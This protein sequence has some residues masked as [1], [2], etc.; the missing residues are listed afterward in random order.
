[1]SEMSDFF[2][3]QS[4]VLLTGGSGFL[5]RAIANQLVSLGVQALHSLS[6]TD[7][8]LRDVT[9]THE[10]VDRY[11]P[12]CVIHCAVQGGG[13]GWMKTHP[14]DSGIDN[15]RMSIKLLIVI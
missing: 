9:A 5:G 14:V 13:I 2:W 12:D 4:S 11:K 7:V 8:D 3:S 10:M 1:M 6:S 15:I